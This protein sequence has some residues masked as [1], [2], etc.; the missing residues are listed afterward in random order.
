MKIGKHAQHIGL[1]YPFYG[2][3][4]GLGTRV[5]L[6]II[7]VFIFFVWFTKLKTAHGLGCTSIQRHTAWVVLVFHS[8]H[9]RI[10]QQRATPASPTSGASRSQIK[11][12]RMDTLVKGVPSFQ[13]TPIYTKPAI[14]A[15]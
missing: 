6:H 15:E 14:F 7:W 1:T 5:K 2:Y 3:L 10:V 8:R 9:R 12:I 11:W 13:Q 4:E